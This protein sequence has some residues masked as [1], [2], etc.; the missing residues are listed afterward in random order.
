MAAGLGRQFLL[1]FWKNWII[2]KRKICCTVTEFVVPLVLIFILVL[3]RIAV[4]SDNIDEGRHW[5]AFNVS[6]LPS[7]LNA[8]N[9]DGFRIAYTPRNNLTARL[10]QSVDDSLGI[11]RKNLGIFYTPLCCFYYLKL[12]FIA[13]GY[14]DETALENSLV[15]E[16]ARSLETLAGIV[17]DFDESTTDLPENVKYS[18]RFHALEVRFHPFYVLQCTVYYA[19]SL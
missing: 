18:L 14:V 1:L 9:D 8:I 7:G 17:F 11:I 3:I 19:R 16:D 6:S 12:C 4:D 2:Q 10:M 13:D 5:P 15:E